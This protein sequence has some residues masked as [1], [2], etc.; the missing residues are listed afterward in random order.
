MVSSTPPLAGN[1]FNWIK[2]MIHSQA[3]SWSWHQCNIS[4]CGSYYFVTLFS[5]CVL[6]P[7][8]PPCILSTLIVYYLIPLPVSQHLEQSSAHQFLAYHRSLTCQA[9]HKSGTQLPFI[10]ID[11]PCPSCRGTPTSSRW[12]VVNSPEF[13]SGNLSFAYSSP[14]NALPYNSLPNYPTLW[15]RRR[16]SYLT[17][18]RA[19]IPCQRLALPED[20]QPHRSAKGAISNGRPP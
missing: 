7:L 15:F 18:P 9:S 19:I 4:R 1:L 16:L 3:S 12:L 17:N 2:I 13:L 6:P 10:I 8:I 20:H 11:W 14:H 5:R